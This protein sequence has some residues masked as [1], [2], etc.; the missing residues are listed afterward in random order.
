ML[1]RLLA[2]YERMIVSKEREFKDC[3]E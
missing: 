2:A 1:C 3:S